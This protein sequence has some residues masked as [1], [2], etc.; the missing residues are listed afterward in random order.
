MGD[1]ARERG[2]S[3]NGHDEIRE[4]RGSVERLEKV[5]T[6]FVVVCER[7]LAANDTKTRTALNA[8]HPDMDRIQ[9]EVDETMRRNGR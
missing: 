4:L 1:P 3:A 6:R 5:V 2:H 8:L 9:K 7:I